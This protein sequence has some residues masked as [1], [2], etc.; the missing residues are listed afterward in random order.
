M[1]LPDKNLLDIILYSAF[2]KDKFLIPDRD[3]WESP[4]VVGIAGALAIG[5][6][7]AIVAPFIVSAIVY[8][9][10]FTAEGVAAGSFG[11]W[12]MSLCGGTIVHGGIIATSQSIGAAGL[13]ALGTSISSGFGASIGI[14]IG[15]LGGSELAKYIKEMDLNDSEK[16]ILGSLVQIENTY[17]NDM[18]IFTLMPA[19]LFNDTI[20]RSFF[21]T[22]IAGSPFTNSKLFRFDFKGNDS[23]KL[24]SEQDKVN[25]TVYNLLISD[26]EKSRIECIFNNDQLVGYNLNLDNYKSSNNVVNVLAD[27]WKLLNG[28]LVINDIDKIRDQVFDNIDKIHVQ[29]NDSINKIRDQF[30]VDIDKIHDQFHDNIDKIRDYFN[31]KFNL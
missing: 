2:L 15:S 23:S 25:H 5:L 17:Q 28:N 12:F 24:K 1:I 18:I 3:I 26:Y 11:A 29:F 7:G 6:V 31:S 16:Q 21:E 9:L 20:L 8:A 22:F 13:G 30:R 19:L 4:W 27:I 10:G 14:L